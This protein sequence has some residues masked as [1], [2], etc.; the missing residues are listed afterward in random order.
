MMFRVRTDEKKHAA[1][2]T[3]KSRKRCQVAAFIIARGDL[4]ATDYEIRSALGMLPDT[5]R[6]RRGE[7][8][9]LG[10]I[11]DSRRSRLSPQGCAM[12]V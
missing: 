5:V 8:E 1:A 6:P 11:I 7:L 2:R 12:T 9:K 3:R 4:G 10:T